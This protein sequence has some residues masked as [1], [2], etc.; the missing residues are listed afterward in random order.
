MRGLLQSRMERRAAYLGIV[1]LVLPILLTL[2]PAIPALALEETFSISGSVRDASG[3][4]VL[5]GCRVYAIESGTGA[6]HVGVTD[7]A[8]DYTIAGLLPGHYK[9]RTSNVEGYVDEWYAVA[10]S[11]PWIGDRSGGGAEEVAIVDADVA[12]VGFSLDAGLS[13]SGYVSDGTTP[14]GSVQVNLVDSGGDVY[15]FESALSQ[16]DGT[17]S[18]QGLP[19]GEYRLFTS[20]S[21]NRD[22]VWY[23]DVH[24]SVDPTGAT[25]TVLTVGEVDLSAVVFSLSDVRSISGMVTDEAGQPLEGICVEAYDSLGDSVASDYTAAD[26]TYT[27]EDLSPDSYKIRTKDSQDYID[28]WYDDV[29]YWGHAGGGGATLIDV[30]EAD[31]TGK[32]FELVLFRTLSGTVTDEE[33]LPLEGIG[34]WAYDSLWNSV[35]SEYTAADG[36]YTIVGLFPTTYKIRTQNSLGYLDEWYDDVIYQNNSGGTGA[37][38][39]DM[40]EADATGKDLQLARGRSISGMVMDEGGLPLEGIYV[41]AYDTLGNAVASDQTATDGTYTLGGLLPDSYK[42]CTYDSPGYLDE[43][44]DDVIFRD[45]ASGAGAVLIDVTEFDVTDADFELAPGR[46]ISGTVTDEEGQPLGGICIRAY[47]TLG[48]Y[49]RDDYTATDGTYTIDGLFPSSYMIRTANSHDYVDEWYDDVLFWG[50]FGGTGATLID[51]G[52]ADA[53]DKDFELAPYRSISG[54]VTDEEGHLLEGIYLHAYDLF[55]NWAG[56]EDTDAAG[57]YTIG[58]LLPG[59]YRVHTSNSQ[60]YFNEWYINILRL[61]DPSGIGAAIIDVTDIAATNVDFALG[62]PIRTISGTVAGEEGQPLEGVEVEVCD[63]LG[64]SV[65]SDQTDAAGTYAIGGLFPTSYKIRTQ[66]SLGYLDEWY[67]DVIYQG[68]YSGTGATLIDVS[69]ADATG[70]DV[71]LALGRSISG[72]VTDEE[73]LALEGI[74][75]RAY[76]VLGNSVASDYTDATGTYAITGLL[77]DSYKILTQNFLGYLDEW[78]DDVF[79]W[80][81]SGG[82]GATLVDLGEADATDKNFE[83][84][85][86][87]TIS[88][89]VI[90]EG[91][92]PLEGVEV[93][94]YDTLGNSVASDPTDATGTYA[95]DGL[96]PTSY[97][98]RT[99]NALG[100]LD[101]WYDNVYYQN[102]SGGTGATLIDVSEADATGTD[103]QLELPRGI[104]GTVTDTEGAPLE[105]YVYLYR[106]DGSYLTSVWSDETTGAYTLTG[107]VP[108][109]YKIRTYNYSGYLD[110]WYDDLPTYNHTQAEATPIDLAAGSASAKDFQLEPY[111][112]IS[113][114]VTDTEGAPLACYV[115]L[116]DADGSHLTSVWSN[117]STGAYTLTGLV[118]GTYTIRTDNSLGYLDEWYDDLP[119]YNHTQAEATPIDLALGS[120]SGKDFQLELGKTIS[121]T[122]TDVGGSALA[123]VYLYA[124]DAQGNQ[125]AY[126]YTASDG[127]YTLIGL[128]PLSYHLRT[129]NYSGYLDEWHD[130][131]PTYNHTQAEATPIDLALGSASAKDFQLEPYRTISGTVTDTEGAPLECY[132][133]LYRADGS[134]LTSVWSDETTGAYTL[135]G[136]VPGSYKIRTYNYSGYLDEWYD[137]LPTYN[138]T[139]A[140]ATPID[141]ALGS[142]SAKDF[143]LELGRSISG[144][145]TDTEGAPLACYIYLYDADGI[146]LTSVWSNATTGA[147]TLSGLVPGTYKIRTYNYSDHLDEWYDSVACWSDPQGTGATLIDVSE[148]AAPGKDFQLEVGKTISGTVTDA[149]GVPLECYVHLHEADGSYLTSALS[150]ETTGAYTLTGLVPT[151]YKIRTSNSLGYLDEWYDNVACWS[152]PQGT[153]ATLIDVREAHATA[154]DFQLEVGKTISGTIT[155]TEGAP[156]ECYV[157]LC[158]A[159]GSHLASALSDETT[160]AYNLTGLA[161]TSYKIRTSNY[162]GYLDEWYDNVYYQNNSGGTGATLIDVSEAA[163]TGKDFQ[164]ARRRSVSGMVTDGKAQPLVDVGVQAFDSLGN[165]AGYDYTDA[166]G[167]YTLTGLAPT[168]YK[169]RTFN[170]LGYLDEWY[171]DVACWS[172]PQGTGATLVDLSESDA[173]D[174]DFQLELGRSISGTVTVEHSGAPL[175]NIGVAAVGADG[176]W[177]WGTTDATGRYRIEGLLPGQYRLIAQSSQVYADEWYDSVFYDLDPS[178][179]EATPVDVSVEDATRMDF[180]LTMGRSISGSVVDGESGLPLQG[181]QVVVSNSHGDWLGDCVTDSNGEYSVLGI[182]PGSFLLRTSNSLGYLDEWYD[183]V[184]YQNNSGGTGAT[185]IDVSEAHAAAKDFQLE[186]PRTISGTVT[187]TEGAP[188]ECHVYLCDAEGNH[189]S[190]VLSDDSSGAYAITGL[191]PGTYKIRTS[192]SLGYLDEW[193]DNVACWSNPQ[194]TGATPID[195]SE[196]DAT[197][198]DFQLRLGRTISGTVTDGEAQPL[199]EVGVQASDILGNYAGHSYTDAS[200]AYTITSLVSGTYKIRTSNSSGYLDEWYDNVIYQG[201]HSGTGATL[202]DVSTTDATNKDFQLAV[203]RTISGTVTDMDRAALECRIYV[204]RADGGSVTSV[205]SDATTGAY[206]LTGL[207]PGTYTIRTQNSLGYLDEWWDDRPTYNHTQAEATPIDLAAGSVSGRDFQLELGKTIS[208]TVTDAAGEPLEDVEVACRTTQGSY[209]SGASDHTA[210]DGTYTI[211]GLVPGTYKLRTVGSGY[212]DEWYDNVVYW[213]NWEGE[214]AEVIDVSTTDATNKDF[215]LES[216]RSISGSVTDTEGAPL[217][218]WVEASDDL[219]NWAASDLTD[220]SGTY[221]ITGL[222]PGSYKIRTGNS[223]GYLDEWY[224]NVIYRNDWEGTGAEAIDLSESDATDKDFQLELGRSISGTVTVEHSGAPLENIGVAAV[225]ADGNWNWGTTDATGRYRIEGLLPGQYRLIAQSSQVYA[226]EWYD[227]VFYDLDPS[228]DEATPVDVSVEDA[229]RMDFALT[230]GRSISGS[231]VDGE[232]GLPLQGVQVVVSNSHGDWLGDC[233]TDS[234]GEYSV[235]GIAPGSFLLRTSNSLGYLDEWYDDVYYQNNSGGT[236]ATP[237]D[238]SADDATAKDF[239]LQPGRT[240]S[241]MVSD[242]SGVPVRC[243]LYVHEA[244]G[245]YVKG[246][247]ND[248]SD[249]T[250][251]ITALLP[252]SYKIRTYNS[253]GY[254]NEWYDDVIYQGNSGGTGATI[255]DVS[256]ADATGRDFQLELGRT[257]SGTVTDDEGGLL[258]D[259]EVVAYDNL[260]DWAGY[261][262]TDTTGTYTITGL[263][264]GTHKIRTYNHSGYFDEWY[265]NVSWRGDYSGTGATLIDVSEADATAKDFQLTL[266]R[267]ISGTVTDEDGAPLECYVYLHDAAGNHLSSV[268]NDETT[269]AY[270]LTGLLP[271]TYKVRTSN[272]L[273]YLDE[274]YDNVIYQGNYSGAGASLID[275]STADAT[276]KGFQL[277]LGRTISGTVT[278]EQGQPLED[279]EVACRT[280]N[281]SYVSGA[282]DY[283]NEDGTYTITGLFP[284]SYKIRT[285]NDQGYL[286][287]WYDDVIYKNNYGGTGATLIDVSTADATGKDLQLELGR[288]ISGAVTD[289]EG[290]HLADVEIVAYDTLGNWAGYDYSDAAGDFAV[291]GLLPGSYKLR[292]WNDQGYLNEWYEG[293]F[294][295]ADPDGETAEWVSVEV[296]VLENVDFSL[297]LGK[298]ISGTISR[299]GGVPIR[300]VT[301]EALDLLGNRTASD[302]TDETGKYALTGLLPAA[303]FVRT[304]TE[305]VNALGWRDEWFN[306]APRDTDPDGSG[307]TSVSVAD[308]DRTDVDF[309]LV[310]VDT[311]PPDTL[312]DSYPFFNTARPGIRWFIVDD[313]GGDEV[314]YRFDGGDLAT[315]AASR[316]YPEVDLVDGEH[317]VEAAAID[318]VGNVDPTPASLDIVVDTVAP[319]VAWDAPSDGTTVASRTVVF[320]GTAGDSGSGAAEVTVEV[321]HGTHR[322]VYHATMEGD[323]ISDYIYPGSASWSKEITLLEGLSQVRVCVVD[324][325][326]NS[327]EWTEWRTI[328]VDVDDAEL[329]VTTLYPPLRPWMKYLALAGYSTDDAGIDT[330][331]YSVDS[332]STWLS[333]ANM[334]L[335]ADGRTYWD[336][337]NSEIAEGTYRVEARSIDTSDKAGDS[338]AVEVMI[339]RTIPGLTW[340]AVVNDHTLTISG[341]LVDGDGSGAAG[342]L[343]GLRTVVDGEVVDARVDEITMDDDVDIHDFIYPGDSTFSRDYTLLD[344]E[345]TVRVQA[346]DAAHNGGPIETV[347]VQVPAESDVHDLALAAGWNLVAGGPLSDFLG[348][349]LFGYVGGSYAS[350]GQDELSAGTGYWCKMASSGTAHIKLTGAP[351]TCALVTGWNLIGN[352]SGE[353][354]GVP[355]GTHA[356]AYDSTVRTY[357]LVEFLEPGQGCWMKA[358]V[359]GNVILRPIR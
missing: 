273:G 200:G 182:A 356:F 121:G 198:K 201:N 108:G 13:I 58:G 358:T 219:G 326:R 309:E 288:S 306:D 312:I 37:T 48:N 81:N 279:V 50:Y 268:L 44:Y 139:Q 260:G 129:Y 20:N 295:S 302:S 250:Y 74:Y 75:V 102:N 216:G 244:D 319:E 3:D 161:P 52:E 352:S 39:I 94:V 134:Y 267:S 261:D 113:G 84:E 345:T 187:D 208:G 252:G 223:S 354:L 318:F 327:S 128:G 126:A 173:T 82:T 97:K 118:P 151:S 100:Y 212:L 111:R 299:P 277:E 274:W 43:W 79:S 239:R 142:A 202:I 313:Y 355:E 280:T 203:G 78:Y 18:V 290:Q 35:A 270:T 26:G 335:Q 174:K 348:Q 308:T 164:L 160:G 222:F 210:S 359:P 344:G 176:N 263:L 351:I 235:L 332:G 338:D 221:T 204:Y 115:Y 36:T 276:G 266:G 190:S 11:I 254:L 92:Q 209:V 168:S 251:T 192:N 40:R 193:Y 238:V 287:E 110:E 71:Q 301:V 340:S 61:D 184:Y 125:Q 1:A 32:D 21:A 63:T 91:G 107:L 249:G 149:E 38:L 119:T 181:V 171:D 322:F 145:V 117:A 275:V 256:E 284:G 264:P 120:A 300:N 105:C 234:N 206:T 162:L 130:D 339:D 227:S 343:V 195:V 224:E 346:R 131:L 140:E 116:Y 213:D 41:R 14:L 188:L 86:Y 76:D 62:H 286:D 98:I 33:G 133:Y 205:W 317:N 183:D 323:D 6:E 47:D 226:D 64:N 172:N 178:G 349:M 296:G 90:G 27:I 194:G 271:G 124:Y 217:E 16:S 232:S 311:L 347:K 353:T 24:L 112:T 228:G 220:T 307:A 59:T 29:L 15:T 214:G 294:V 229:T 136:L 23:G 55:G 242:M 289:V 321:Q 247:W 157:Y 196:T 70:T 143:Q 77:P 303:Y 31:A 310:A 166:T 293:A 103:F 155:D 19:A 231:V 67:D 106:A 285:W 357:V 73:A 54:T 324:A 138:H 342:L 93:E 262:N 258:A 341:T 185:P 4:P 281:G 137:D 8:G 127:T 199:V 83:L 49:V 272:S 146:Y 156:L 122:V 283:T 169:V 215:Q 25:A 56:S 158:D 163:A 314:Q 34:I 57:T 241:G 180:A 68:N 191:F 305:P 186:L 9:L 179:D 22:D 330:V 65:A 123:G 233:V 292:T 135:T 152:N 325:A 66:N 255:I 269:G 245:T 159:D 175:E 320:S 114:T 329:P 87:R 243:Y 10:A 316:M 337:W 85:F 69:E 132:V 248:E 80:D 109:S 336:I 282:Y 350:F 148:A 246:V 51:L 28:E 236:G 189:L 331:E 60:G 177:N 53:A 278:D 72:T 154:K 225:G 328:T 334:E 95:I 165:W 88:G 170:S 253:L 2:L 291:A 167:A 12:P 30:S 144:T 89:T 259:V 101:E 297:E 150:D 96:F 240:I 5:H 104:S 17:Y 230:M 218:C 197:G 45:S 333:V 257:I 42:I 237:I 153:G 141:L 315:T 147:Y 304:G 207:L 298:T 211:T 99:S 265:D 7:A 46:T